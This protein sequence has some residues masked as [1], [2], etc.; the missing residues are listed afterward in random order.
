MKTPLD[1]WRTR[2]LAALFIVVF[3]G[4]I[5]RLVVELVEPLLPLATVGIVLILI[6]RL[7]LRR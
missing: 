1:R 3:A 7:I 4:A 5:A 2:L 6:Y